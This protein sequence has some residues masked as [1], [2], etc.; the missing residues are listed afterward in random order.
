M[1]PDRIEELLRRRPPDE[2]PHRVELGAGP[3]LATCRGRS[4]R[5][6][7]PARPCGTGAGRHGRRRRHRHRDRAPRGQ[8]PRHD[9]DAAVRRRRLVVGRLVVGRRAVARS[10]GLRG[11]RPHPVARRALRGAHARADAGPGRAAAMRGEQRGT[12]RV[13]VGRGDRIDGGRR[14]ADQPGRRPVPSRDPDT[15]RAGRCRRVEDRDERLGRRRRAGRPRLGGRRARCRRRVD[16]RMVELVRS[17]PF[18]GR[19]PSG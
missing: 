12:A 9:P 10:D 7:G 19:C 4:T 13:G 5:R 6:A 16:R 3:V 18:R 11:R 8:A 1:R 14:P 15:D 17:A 2:R